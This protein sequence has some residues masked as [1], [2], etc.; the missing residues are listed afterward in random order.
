MQ[1][2]SEVR[3]TIRDYANGLPV[4]AIYRAGSNLFIFGF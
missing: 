2:A 3:L 4:G 1:S